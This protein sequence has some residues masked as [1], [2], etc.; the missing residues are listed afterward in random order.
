MESHRDANY[1]LVNELQ[2]KFRSLPFDDAAARE[3]A[4]IR[5]DLAQRGNSI[6]PNDTMIAAIA[7][8]QHVTLV[9]NNS[10]EFS[11]VTGLTIEVWQMP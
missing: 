7:I 4:L 5:A 11:R 9:T 10:G 1:S 2:A 6:G 3:Y 8:S